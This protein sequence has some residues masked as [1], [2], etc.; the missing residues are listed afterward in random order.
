MMAKL[1]LLIVLLL[2]A[3][4]L[5]LQNSGAVTVRFLFW[6]AS[7]SGFLLVVLPLLAGVVIGFL[8]AKLGGRSPR[9]R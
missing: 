2:L 8:G 1:W 6:H 9:A 7:L 4:I 5:G 3:L